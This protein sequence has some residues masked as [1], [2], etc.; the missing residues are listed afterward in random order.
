LANG[1]DIAKVLADSV[2]AY[3]MGNF[4]DVGKDFG[5]LLRKILLS[6]V[7]GPNELVLPE[8]KRA[9]VG[10]DVVNGVIAGLFVN[11]TAV[12]ITST[13]DASI[14]IFID[15]HRCIAEEAPYFSAAMNALYLG[16]A[17]ITTNIEQWQLQQHGIQTGTLPGP[18][19]GGTLNGP[20][21]GGAVAVNGGVAAGGGANMQM[22]WMNQLSGL[23]TNIPVMMDRCGFTEVQRD[24]M[25]DALKNMK[26][27][28]LAFTIPGP[29][30]RAQAV[31]QAGLKFKAATEKFKEG[32]YHQ[33]GLLLGGL[34]RDLLLTVYPQQYHVDD[35][36]LRAFVD[37]KKNKQLGDF[38]HNP[39]G[40]LALMAGGFSAVMLLGLSLV[41]VA[42]PATLQ[43]LQ[44]PMGEDMEAH[45]QDAV[46]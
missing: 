9:E 14:N 39:T 21:A 32:K 28:S 19:T 44:A 38:V 17:Q 30:D 13:V 5:T 23:M 20:P 37:S 10:Q 15:L 3:Q 2:P 34:M 41:R 27:I 40:S 29:H 24:M 8:G 11:G 7:S 43:E 25:E 1:I 18:A 45:H 22:N 33:F 16:I 35:G 42:R 31:N 36:Q 12:R 6:R 46:E 26:T 4:K